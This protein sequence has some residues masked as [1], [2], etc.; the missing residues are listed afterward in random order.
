VLPDNLTVGGSLYLEGTSISVLPDNLTVGGFLYLRDTSISNVVY[1][2]GCGS[3]KRTIFAANM[4]DGVRIFA[5]CFQGSIDAFFAAVDAKYSG[6]DAVEYKKQGL[7][8]FAEL[9][10]MKN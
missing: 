3:P 5:G 1:R 2:H 8:C 7:E 10:N 9:A 4:K 6:D